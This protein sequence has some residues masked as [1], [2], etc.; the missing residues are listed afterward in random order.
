MGYYL[1]YI[2]PGN[3]EDILE[4]LQ[5]NCREAYESLS[6]EY[7]IGYLE[8]KFKYGQFDLHF[9]FSERIIEI[10]YPQIKYS[11]LIANDSASIK[12]MKS[13]DDEL[14]AHFPDKPIYRVDEVLIEAC[15]AEDLLWKKAINAFSIFEEWIQ[16]QEVLHWEKIN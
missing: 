15:T 8:G 10:C 16:N 11:W 9:D 3:E 6:E 13:I 2:L 1:T 14:I 12:Q 7:K 4:N 5:A